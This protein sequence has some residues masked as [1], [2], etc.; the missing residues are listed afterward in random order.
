MICVCRNYRHGQCRGRLHTIN[1]QVIQTV[2]DHNHEPNHSVGQLVTARTSMSNAAKQSRD[3]THAIVA[4]AAA[5]LSDNAISSLP[6]LRNLK[7][8]VQRIRQRNQN[9][10]S[11]PTSRDSIV[12]DPQYIIAAR[13]RTLLQFD[14]GPIEQRVLIFSTKKQIKILENAN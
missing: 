7:R 3:T 11:L 14:S 4:D 2:G 8:N 13:D 10:L 1:N 12:I 6:N 9:P 5:T